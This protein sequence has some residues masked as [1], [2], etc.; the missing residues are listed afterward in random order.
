M[1]IA[2]RVPSGY[3]IRMRSTRILA[4]LIAT[5]ALTTA[6]AAQQRRPADPVVEVF[7]TSTCG[8][9]SKWIDHLKSAGF[10]VSF[11]DMPQ[12]ELDKLKAKRG[13]PAS[14]HSCH[15][16]LLGRYVLEGHIP[17]SEVKRL[18]REKPDVVGIAVPGMPPGSPGMEVADRDLPT[19]NVLSFD[20]QGKTR[21]FST[22][23]P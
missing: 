13:V 12:T 18:L 16:A 10:N 17:A 22:Q 1:W 11:I 20:K 23:K 3:N 14:V 9:C 5:V 8:C 19:Y 2:S 4:A 7:K 15:T 6:P 21:V